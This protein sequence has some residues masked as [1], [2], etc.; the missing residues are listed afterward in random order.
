MSSA[1]FSI[2]VEFSNIM[3]PQ[4]INA[5]ARSTNMSQECAGKKVLIKREDGKYMT[6][7]RKTGDWAWTDDRDA[8]YIYDYNADGVAQQLQ[9]VERR[10]EAK[11]S[12]EIYA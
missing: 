8:A 1:L 3:T 10:Y 2:M 11:W 5:W 12:A 9:E 7:D 6:R 4:E